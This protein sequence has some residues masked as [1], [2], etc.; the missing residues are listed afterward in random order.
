MGKLNAEIAD[1]VAALKSDIVNFISNAVQIPSLPGS[2]K[3]VQTVIA[4]KLASLDLDVDTFAVKPEDLEKHPAFSDD[5]FPFDNRINVIGKW[6]GAAAPGKLGRSLIL[7][8]HVDVVSPGDENL[9]TDSPWSGKVADGK[10]YGRGSTDMKAGIAAAIFAIEALK[11]LR[12]E[13]A[14]DIVIESVVGEETGGCGTLAGILK[15][16]RADAAIIIEPTALKICP[17]QSGALSFRLHVKGRAMHGC[18]KNKGVS[19]IA[20]FYH[21]FKSIEVFEQR[22][23]QHYRNPLYP[24]PMNVAPISIGVLKSGEWHST[25]PDQLVAEGRYGIFPDESVEHAKEQFATMIRLA[26]EQDD[27]MRDHPPHVEWF[28]GQFES[29][30]TSLD[31]PIIHVLSECHQLI[32]GEKP[33]IEGVTYGSDLRL[34]TNHG[35]IP[36]VL[37]GPGDVIDAHTVD[38]CIVIEEVMRATNILAL[39]IVAWCGR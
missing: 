20:K 8:G 33:K 12:I 28:E 19:A 30:Q 32:A 24:D 13:L 23:H 2:E 31:D 18:M 25:V 38:E 7:N 4:H 35:H 26:A 22:R 15:G 16:Y 11:K 17:V 14:G 39:T 5:G 27:W 29:G 36:A 1:A 34:F 37:Y 9:W 3:D 6:K 10:I 21:L